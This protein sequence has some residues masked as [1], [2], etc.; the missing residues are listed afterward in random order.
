MQR[1]IN[2]LSLTL[3]LYHSLSP[4]LSLSFTFSTMNC[5]CCVPRLRV[6]VVAK[7]GL[8]ESA[9]DS[10]FECSICVNQSDCYI[11]FENANS[12]IRDTTRCMDFRK[13]ASFVSSTVKKI[14]R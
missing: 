5:H 9:Y 6:I 11:N 13:Y 14:Q 8:V 4:S 2:S 10:D 12:F 1:D 7:R 3:S